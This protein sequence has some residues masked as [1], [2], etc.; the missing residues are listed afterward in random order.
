MGGGV[1]HPSFLPFSSTI[2]HHNPP[3]P[4]SR[5]LCPLSPPPPPAFPPISHFSSPSPIFPIFPKVEDFPHSSL[6]KNQPT[7]LIDGK[8]EILPVSDPL[9]W[10]VVRMLV[11]PVHVHVRL[12][13]RVFSMHGWVGV[14][15]APVV[16]GVKGADSKHC[17]R[18]EAP[19]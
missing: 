12:L 13:R 7:A 11:L 16:L 6:C 9:L 15:G 18:W 17:K 2:S 14:G 3:Q 1:F 19:S 4:T 5:V 8:M 10:W